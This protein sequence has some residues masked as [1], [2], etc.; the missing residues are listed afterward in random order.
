MIRSSTA[1]EASSIARRETSAL[2]S[3]I[4][5]LR[6]WSAVAR[7]NLAASRCS[8]IGEVYAATETAR[9]RYRK[10]QPP[11]HHKVSVQPDALDPPDAGRREAVLVLQDAEI[12][13]TEVRRR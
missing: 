1:R 7:L 12:S 11:E 9:A 5:A 6:S 2:L 8:L 13:S 10:R 4:A 3:R